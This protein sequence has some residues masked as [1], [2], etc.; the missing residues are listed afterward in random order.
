[1]L[2]IEE[3]FNKIKDDHKQQ[4]QKLTQQKQLL[5]KKDMKIAELEIEGE[6]MRARLQSLQNKVAFLKKSEVDLSFLSSSL[7]DMNIDGFASQLIS[8][9][10]EIL[11]IN[12]NLEE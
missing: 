9:N 5:R 12:K 10:K 6:A 1:M 7:K 2:E 4:I 11:K 8:K 3:T